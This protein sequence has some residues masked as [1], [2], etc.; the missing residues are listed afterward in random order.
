MSGQLSTLT[1]WLKALPD[2]TLQA[3]LELSLCAAWTLLFTGQFHAAQTGLRKVMVSSQAIL[4]TSADTLQYQHLHEEAGALGRMLSA[5]HAPTALQQ[6]RGPAP[7]DPWVGTP[8]WRSLVALSLGFEAVDAG[9]ENTARAWFQEAFRSSTG[10]GD[11]LVPML[12]LCQLA[13]IALVQ[14]HLHHAAAWYRQALRLATTPAGHPLPIAGLAYQGLGLL[15][16]EWN[17]L[18]AAAQ[19][20]RTSIELC[21][22]WAEAWALDSYLALARVFA[23]QGDQNA[24][25]E[26]IQQAE[27]IALLL[28]N[29]VFL[30]HVAMSQAR[31]ALLQGQGEAVARWARTASVSLEA[32]VCA[33]DEQKY[34]LLV[35]VLLAQGESNKALHL[36]AQ[37][38]RTVEAA[39]RTGRVIE[40][41]ALQSLALS[42][43]NAINRAMTVLEQALTLAAPEGYVRLFVEFGPPMATLLQQARACQILPD[44]TD[45]LLTVI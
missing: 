33:E 41:L 24:V 21:T 40:L 8:F 42:A 26:A 31:I 39:G 17:D 12:A 13:E 9:V 34:L 11:L 30:E 16:R 15:L 37:L 6:E 22:Q 44:Y 45:V 43:Q 28:G 36:V 32:D 23:A 4:H 35:R 2:D 10:Q 18:E 20:L 7:G 5:F 3:H 14:G 29:E 1:R 38:L 27:R 19:H 25:L